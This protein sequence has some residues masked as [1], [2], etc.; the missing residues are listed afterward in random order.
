MTKQI[1]RILF[2]IPPYFEIDDYISKQLKLKAPIFTLPSGVLS[3]SAYIKAYLEREIHIEVIDLNL[4]AFKLC[5][6]TTEITAELKNVI[7]EKIQRFQPD[8]IGISALFDTCY[9]HLELISAASKAV[10]ND[11]L[12]VMGGGIA[13]NLYNKILNDFPSIDALCFGEGEIPMCELSKAEN[14]NEYFMSCSAWI[15]RDSIKQG[16][17][18]QA[19]FVQNL[20]E[21]PFPDYKLMNINEYSGREIDKLSSSK[22]SQQLSIYTSRGC[23]F[24]CVFCASGTVHGKKIRFMSVKKVIDEVKE[25]VNSYNMG[26]LA[27]EDDHF[28]ADKKRAKDI[29]RKLSEFDLRIEFPNGMA[30]YA[31]DNKIGSLLKKAGVT[32]ISLAMESGSDF[33]L[34]KIIDKPLKL[35]MVKSAVDIL[36]NNEICV[37]CCIVLGLPGE[38]ETHRDET[39]QKILDTGFDWTYFNIA[40]PV[41]GSRLYDICKE[42]GYLINNDL[43]GHHTSKCNIKTSEIDPEYIEEKAYLMN[44]DANFVRNHNLLAGNYKKASLYFKDIVQTYPDHAFAHHCLAQSYEGLGGNAESISY[45]KNKFAELTNTNSMW[46]K[47]AK[48][49]KLVAC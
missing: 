26:V 49:F 31:I 44:L 8:I 28:L 34:K 9:N 3:M 20:D 46:A 18:P 43:G 21:I 12:V 30:I 42:K 4:E 39:M 13:T 40:V 24:N 17:V 16:C 2:V 7:K 25:L 10:K 36:R 11:A 29:L 27:I 6:I 45:H 38:L 41:V 35:D 14:V 47:Y 23:P 15:T 37:H 19:V 32:T 5:S 33:V 22:N 48:I 1:D